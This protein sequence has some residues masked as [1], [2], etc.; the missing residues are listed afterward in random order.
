M[1][2]DFDDIVLTAG[3]ISFI[4][5]RKLQVNCYDRNDMLPIMT[6]PMDTVI[7]MKNFKTFVDNKIYS[8]LPRGISGATAS[9][10][11]FVWQS[12]GLEE[13]E[14]VFITKK[15]EPIE[16]E[17]EKYYALIDTANGHMQKLFSLA[18]RAKEMY[19]DS[20]VLMV[21]NVANPFTYVEYCK[22]NVD[23]IRI[24]IGNGQACLTTA[25]TGVG[26]PMASLI[27]ECADLKK[28]YYL[29]GKIVADGGFKNFS[30]INKALALGADYVMLGSMLNKCLESC[31][32][33]VTLHG[34]NSSPISNE[35][36]LE[37]LNLPDCVHKP[38]KMYRGMSTKAV[39]KAWGKTVL[40]T[41]EGI[42]KYNLIEYTL[43]G[44]VENL[45]DFLKSAMS[46]TSSANLETFKDA[47][48]NQITEA[49]FRRFNK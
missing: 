30:D 19:G 12:Y 15:I 36:A 34:A 47:N 27:K 48:F 13:F 33:C 24:G 44:F 16:S 18:K 7:D 8:V 26:Y 41:A 40:T 42:T 9:I 5:S 17:D 23:Y 10:N 46:Y 37:L 32:P 28:K 14:E 3:T 49:A 4:N 45:E 25:N 11:K 29:R 6:A 39:Q 22:I 38:Y 20:L 35:R 1:K 21:G 31:T 43:A 2:F